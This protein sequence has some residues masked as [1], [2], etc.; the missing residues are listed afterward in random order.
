M[1][2]HN[3]A[4]LERIID[5]GKSL[6]DVRPGDARAEWLVTEIKHHAIGV[7][8]LKR[9]AFRSRS[10]WSPQM[11]DSITVRANM[12]SLNDQIRGS[13]P[14]GTFFRCADPFSKLRPALIHEQRWRWDAWEGYHV[15]VYGHR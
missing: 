15:T 7:A 3:I 4:F 5:P 6:I 12:I 8:I 14:R 10:I 1:N 11:L 2:K 9:Y 13:E